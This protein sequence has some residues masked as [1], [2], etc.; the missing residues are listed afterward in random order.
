VRH[1]RVYRPATLGPRPGLVVDLHAARA[2]GFLE[3]LATRFDAQ[4]DRLQWIVAYPDGVADGWEPFACCYHPGIDDVAFIANLID[5]LEATDGIDPDR[6]YVTGLSRG[7][8]I[9]YRLACELSPRLAAIAPVAGNMADGSG[10]V[11]GVA[12]RPDRPVS[13]L[14][15][16]GSA[17][18]QVPVAG[19]GRF[20]PLTDVLAR[21]RVL[22]GC[23]SSASMTV[24][25]PVVTTTWRCREGSDVQSVVVE[26]A[27]HTWPGIPLSSL[28]WGPAASLDASRV[29][30]DFFAA[31]PRAPAA[32]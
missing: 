5:H 22:D 10:D 23:E 4:A 9:A 26:G 28:P 32:P 11:G 7:G 18:S 3:E 17:D 1:F 2:N 24:M 21:W 12:C 6:V 20:A 30:A 15:I 19:G 8:M 13:V 27:G 29:I 14:S 16:H 25:G 31:H